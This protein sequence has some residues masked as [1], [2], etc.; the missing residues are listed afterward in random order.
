MRRWV[1]TP[2][3]F[4]RRSSPD[5]FGHTGQGSTT[6]WAE[7]AHRLAIA[8][9]TNGAPSQRLPVRHSPSSP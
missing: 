3:A 7:P 8:Y 9:F 5:A 6:A 2:Q 4:G 1:A